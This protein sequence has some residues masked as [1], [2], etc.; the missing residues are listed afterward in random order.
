MAGASCGGVGKYVNPRRAYH[1]V[2]IAESHPSRHWVNEKARDQIARLYDVVVVVI[3][4]RGA[5]LYYILRSPATLQIWF[6]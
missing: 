2:L 1:A 5:I 3:G 6:R 4:A